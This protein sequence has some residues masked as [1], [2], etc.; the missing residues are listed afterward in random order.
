MSTQLVLLV[1]LGGF[2]I[3]IFVITLIVILVKTF[4]KKNNNKISQQEKEKYLTSIGV[5]VSKLKDIVDDTVG[6]DMNFACTARPPCDIGYKVSENKKGEECCYVDMD[7]MQPT[8]NEV[9]RTMMKDIA[10]E[11]IITETTELVVSSL[12]RIYGRIKTAR[13]AAKA[14][15]GA[16]V[17][18]KLAT[19]AALTNGAKIAAKTAAKSALKLGMG[20]VGWAMLVFDIV[21][22]AL[23]LYDPVGYNSFV[24]NEV[25]M[26]LRNIAEHNFQ[27][28]HA[29]NEGQSIPLMADFDYKNPSGEFET[30]HVLPEITKRMNEKVIDSMTEEMIEAYADSD[31][32]AQQSY[33]E[34][35]SL[36]LVED[37]MET[38]DYKKEVCET[39]QK[40][41][42]NR[43]KVEWINNVGCSMT[44]NECK[45]YNEY[46]LKQDP[47]NQVLGLFTK[48]YRKKRGGT[49]KKPIMNTYRLPKEACIASPLAPYKDACTSDKGVWDDDEGMCSF[50]KSYCTGQ[51]QRFHKMDNGIYNCVLYPGQEI[52][53]MFFGSTVTR[54]MVST[55]NPDS[56]KRLF[57]GDL[58]ILKA[59]GQTL[60][61]VSLGPMG[62]ALAIGLRFGGVDVD[63][64]KYTPIGL[65]MNPQMY[66]VIGDGFDDAA[67]AFED[68]AEAYTNLLSNNVTM[69]LENFKKLGEVS[70]K[71][72]KDA[73][74]KVAEMG[75]TGIDTVKKLL[76][77][78]FEG[79]EDAI[80]GGL[81]GIEDAWDS[82]CFFC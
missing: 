14:V 22:A 52:A 50:K 67:K 36:K 44:K 51:G 38:M 10:K 71:F 17:A 18:A 62:M 42:G 21:S 24:S 13:A 55:G 4:N 9:M 23:D 57:D 73:A 61:F 41:S 1:G 40:Q 58:T 2:F 70:A 31:L 60:A 32:V 76:D 3:I 33:L 79:I 6:S 39:Y 20:P 19:K 74:K 35:N 45:R 27:R 47:E 34:T 11:L 81:S 48:R 30:K 7:K 29:E 64:T 63:L 54:L 77:A 66:N 37:Y 59:W 53:E 49:T 72:G 56:Y 78:G 69:M 75:Q 80:D 46:Q 12:Y 26:N 82:I 16:S 8:R 43:N 15:K 65:L 28:M 5:D 68:A 25:A